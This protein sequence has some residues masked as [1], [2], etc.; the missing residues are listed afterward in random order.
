MAGATRYHIIR[1]DSSTKKK[2]TIRTV[3]DKNS[4]FSGNEKYI[5]YTDKGANK[6]NVNYSYAVWACKTDNG[7]NYYSK[8]KAS[9]SNVKCV[10]QMYQKIY[11]RN[12]VTLTSH[13]GGSTVSRKFRPGTAIVATGFG[14][15]KYKFYDGS[16]S[17]RRLFYVVVGRVRKAK[18]DYY[19]KNNSGYSN[20]SAEL[21]V[22]GATAAGKVKKSSKSNC[23]IWVSTYTQHLYIFTWDKTNKKWKLNRHWECATGMAESPTNIGFNYQIHKKMRSYIGIPYWNCFSSLNGIHG[24]RSSYSI[25]G[26]PHSHGCVRN[27]NEKARW[28]YNWCN[29][30]TPVITY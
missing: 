14:G 26:A 20:V 16:G 2:V 19:K 25:D 24:K 12:T 11:L 28:I 4:T 23:L 17:R 3:T 5:S 15:G 27:Y 10:R 18:A 8:E 29:I 6:A 9:K 7:K 22:N 21:F 30:G 1:Y 13:G